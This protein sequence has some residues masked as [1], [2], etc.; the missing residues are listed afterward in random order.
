[1]NWIH[2]PRPALI[3]MHGFSCSG[4]TWVSYRL[5]QSLY[6]VL[7][8]SDIERKRLYGIG[9]RASSS[10]APGE[11]LYGTDE[12]AATHDHMLDIARQLLNSGHR[13]ILDASFLRSE[14]RKRARS[15]AGE[16]GVP[17]VLVD[18]DAASDVLE[19][20]IESRQAENKDASEANLDVLEHQRRHSDP[21]DDETDGPVVRYECRDDGDLDELARTIGSII[22]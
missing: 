19:R 16:K 13:V 7:I 11:G 2:R 22:E 3:V 18:V 5:L 9:E 1:M 8:L 15:L 10:S 6:A 12:S 4:K 17:F 14:E 20:R 21:L